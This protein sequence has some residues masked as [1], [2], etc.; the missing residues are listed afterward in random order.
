MTAGGAKG[1]VKIRISCNYASSRAG[2]KKRGKK[3][4]EVRKAYGSTGNGTANRAANASNMVSGDTSGVCTCMVPF[5]CSISF[6]FH[7]DPRL[8]HFG[9]LFVFRR[10]AVFGHQIQEF[11]VVQYIYEKLS[12]DIDFSAKFDED[13][14]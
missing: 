8:L 10:K 9:S 14:V 7:W 13:G 1:T 12:G 11:K 6:P 5:R 3:E 4:V 2:A